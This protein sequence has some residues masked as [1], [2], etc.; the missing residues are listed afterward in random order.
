MPL[1][2]EGPYVWKN[3]HEMGLKGPSTTCRSDDFV[4]RPCLKT[5]FD[6]LVVAWGFNGHKLAP[7]AWD[8]H[9][10]QLRIRSTATRRWIVYTRAVSLK[11]RQSSGH[12]SSAI[13]EFGPEK[14]AWED[15][16]WRI[17][18]GPSHGSCVLQPRRDVEGKK[19]LQRASIPFLKVIFLV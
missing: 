15:C 16:L 5:S 1:S 18:N 8:P 4:W 10:W 7:V 11:C 17:R 9:S 12:F 6:D 3:K 13:T 14:E 19:A 2:H